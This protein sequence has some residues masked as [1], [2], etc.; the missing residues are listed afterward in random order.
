MNK[1]DSLG[2][3]C[4]TRNNMVS[5]VHKR[6]VVMLKSSQPLKLDPQ[7]PTL[8]NV[9]VNL[10]IMYTSIQ[11]TEFL[12]FLTAAIYITLFLCA[13]APNVKVQLL[14]TEAQ[15]RTF[16]S[17]WMG[18]YYYVFSNRMA[19]LENFIKRSYR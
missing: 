10:S 8:H 12:E 11:F 3:S 13:D 15:L 17:L 7:I 6:L 1:E 16:I 4:S 2:G 18:Y 5:V 19:N 9:I 14:Q